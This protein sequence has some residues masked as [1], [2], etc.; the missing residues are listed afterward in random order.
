MNHNV[1][2]TLRHCD[3]HVCPYIPTEEMT[4]HVWRGPKL[5]H[6][7]FSSESMSF[8]ASSLEIASWE[9]D[10]RRSFQHSESGG[11]LN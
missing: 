5:V 4:L 2:I 3:S 1:A 11:S 6:V 10:K 9:G 7:L 8:R